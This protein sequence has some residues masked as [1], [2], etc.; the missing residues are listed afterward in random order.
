MHAWQG[1]PCPQILT[2]TA[3]SVA[4]THIKS[5][6]Q[7]PQTDNQGFFGIRLE[8]IGGLGAH[9]AG[10]ILAEAGVLRMGLNGANFS[11]YGSEKKGS[12]V[13]A[14]VRFCAA[15]QEVRTSSPVDRPHLVAVF[16]EGLVRTEPVLWGLLPEGAIIVNSLRSPSQVWDGLGRPAAKVGAVNA[17]AIAV[18]ESSRVNTVMLGAV[19]RASGFIKPEAVKEVIQATL[20]ERYPQLLASN[21]RAFDRGFAELALEDFSHAAAAVPQNYARHAPPFGYLD[22]PLGGA[23]MNPG[24]TALKDLSVSRNGFLPAFHRER[25][26]DC[27]LCDLVCPDFCFVWAV[28]RKADGLEAIRLKGIDYQFCKGCLKCIDACPTLAL[29]TEREEEGYAE[30]HSVPLFPHL[31]GFSQNGARHHH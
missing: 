23:V 26:V 27:A 21:L 25:C 3:N 18:E 17:L 1:P 8:S 10:Q 9:V 15:E 24:N 12:P 4:K 6:T 2:G 13:K 22:A 28:E 19:A 30:R 7:L 16:H 29:S 20:G 5:R 31:E 11:S 14:Y